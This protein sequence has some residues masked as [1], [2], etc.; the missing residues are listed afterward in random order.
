M[1]SLPWGVVVV[2]EILNCFWYAPRGSFPRV[3]FGEND[4]DQS[5]LA[6]I[7]W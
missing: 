6:I 5:V 4:I 2:R 1:E 7:L 3:I